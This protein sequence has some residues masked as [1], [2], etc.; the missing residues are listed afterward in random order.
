[1]VLLAT[2]ILWIF[3]VHFHSKC[4]QSIH[5][6]VCLTTKSFLCK[7]LMSQHSTWK[8]IIFSSP[9]CVS[10]MTPFIASQ[11]KRFIHD[12]RQMRKSFGWVSKLFT[13]EPKVL[14]NIS[15]S[16]LETST[17]WQFLV[18]WPGWRNQGRGR[19]LVV[20][21]LFFWFCQMQLFNM[22]V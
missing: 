3:L 22:N 12:H 16:H 13:F 7:N 18:S 21:I 15:S 14:P 10:L 20:R 17:C 5:H 11:A 2:V 4:P 19:T 9:I 6:K 1:M 8:Q